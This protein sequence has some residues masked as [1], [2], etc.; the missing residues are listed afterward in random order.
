MKPKKIIKEKDAKLYERK[1]EFGYQYSTQKDFL[2]YFEI[3]DL[4][5][6]I[7]LQNGAQIPFDQID[8]INVQPQ[9][10]GFNLQIIKKGS[11][12]FL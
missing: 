5:K 2:Y 1:S 3:N 12:Y 6:S 4:Q 10:D 11:K 7:L 9:Y 8:D